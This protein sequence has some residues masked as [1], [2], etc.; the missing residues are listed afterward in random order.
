MILF[1]LHEF[2]QNNFDK[3]ETK[4]LGYVGHKIADLICCSFG[5]RKNARL[6]VWNDHINVSA[7]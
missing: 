7:I 1:R 5:S 4:D 6:V 2:K 3:Y